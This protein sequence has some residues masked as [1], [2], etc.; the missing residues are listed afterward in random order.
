MPDSTAHVERMRPEAT[1][2]LVRELSDIVGKA[3]VF[4]DPEMTARYVTDWTGRWHGG[5]TAVVRPGCTDEVARV[6]RLCHASRIGVV[7]QGGNTGLV[8]GSIPMHGEIVLSSERLDAIEA[9]DPIARTLAAGAGTT[10]AAAHTAAQ[11]AGLTFG[12]DLAS[13][14]SATL[15]GIVATNAGGVRVIKYGDTRAQLLGIEAVLSDGSVLTRWKNFTKD[16]VGY[17]LPGL[18]AGSEGTLAVVTRVLMKLHVPPTH[19]EVVLAGVET[20]ESALAL[21]DA[22]RR[23]GLTIEAAELMTDDGMTLVLQ[24]RNLRHPLGESAPYYLL[25]EASGSPEVATVLLETL[26]Q[27]GD[28]VVDATLGRGRRL[29]EFRESHT[30]S[31]NAASATPPVKLDVTTPL[32]ELESFIGVLRREIDSVFPSVR[33]IVFGHIADGN[34]HVNLLD[35]APEAAQRITELVFELVAAHDGSISAEHG[36]GRSKAP[37]IH[38]GRSSVDIDLMKA[39]RHGMDPALILNPHI[40]PAQHR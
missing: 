10:V 29:W 14:D 4:T 34:V 15:G 32:A 2:R 26:E 22:F 33:L 27:A 17:H 3:H 16:N 7:T 39:I 36:V 11:R 31:V 24:H 12:I 35:V 18:L 28:L 21:T 37:W 20:V 23:A 8:G 13:R 40:L 5:T 30:E 19:T 25:V 38:L 6:M 9:V 1:A